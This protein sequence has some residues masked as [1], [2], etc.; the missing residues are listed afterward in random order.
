LANVQTT[1]RQDKVLLSLLSNPH[2]PFTHYLQLAVPESCN[3]TTGMEEILAR[4]RVN[5]SRKTTPTHAEVHQAGHDNG[6]LEKLLTNLSDPNKASKK[7]EKDPKD[8]I[9]PDNKID[10]DRSSGSDRATTDSYGMVSCSEASENSKTDTGEILRMKQELEAAKSVISRQE[11]ELAETRNLKHTM[12]QAMGPASEID[13]GGSSEISEQ[14]IN[15]LQSAF[16]ATAR[17]FTTGRNNG[18]RSQDDTHSE[19][20]EFS[21]GSYPPRG[22]W[23]N[24]SAPGL[25]SMP[26]LTGASIL[27]NSRD[28]RLSGQA[29][30]GMYGNPP[31]MDTGLGAGRVFSGSSSS[32]L[33]YDARMTNDLSLYS[34]NHGARRMPY[35]SNSTLTDPLTPFGSLPGV[36]G[37]TS[38]PLSPL[39]A[40][41]QY[42]LGQRGIG[43]QP[44]PIASNF[45]NGPMQGLGSQWPMT[46]SC[47]E[48]CL[49]LRLISTD[50]W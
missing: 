12:D 1:K 37:M 30:G 9:C 38:P 13:F 16:N 43:L 23:N 26:D 47:F 18:W 24:Q 28:A 7:Q 39:D 25:G 44:S 2:L 5:D 10:I 22:I 45:P 20:S 3:S 31:S 46:V 36:S 32:G 48:S 49:D 8:V 17:P 50:G 6:A 19:Q 4:L 33:G 34:S 11:Q 40:P 35:R 21:A 27:G 42:G 14:T 15:H 41:G 29:Y